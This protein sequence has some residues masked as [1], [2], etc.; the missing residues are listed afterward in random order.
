MRRT[1]ALMGSAL[2]G[3]SG[4]TWTSKARAEEA[5]QWQNVL[6]APSNA[7]EV[8]FAS[9]YTQGLGHIAPGTHVVNVAGAGLAIAVDFD[10]RINPFFSLGVESQFQEF[11]TENN[12]GSRGLAANIGVTGHAAPLSRIDPFLRLGTGYRL[13]WDTQPTVAPNQTLVYHGFDALSLKLGVDFRMNRNAAFAPV[14]GA[15]LQTFSWVNGTPLGTT[16]L[17]TFVYGGLQLR[18]DIGETVPQTP[19]AKNTP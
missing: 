2:L 18:F 17:A 14:I 1:I 3:L 4:G 13:L 12:E 9:G 5:P 16:Q 19:I 11:V 7:F 8:K 6:P 15:D 10:Y